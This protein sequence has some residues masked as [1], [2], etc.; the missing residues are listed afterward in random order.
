MNGLNLGAFN[1]LNPA[2]TCCYALNLNVKD[3]NPGLPITFSGAVANAVDANL[4]S[5][6]CGKVY[7]ADKNGNPVGSKLI[8]QT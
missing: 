3:R 2:A 1:A 4:Q 6:L 7:C 5:A 8:S